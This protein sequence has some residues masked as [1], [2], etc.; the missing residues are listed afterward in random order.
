[1]KT[2]LAALFVMIY[3]QILSQANFEITAIDSFLS[4]GGGQGVSGLNSVT[5]NNQ[6]HLTY[7]YTDQNS[8]TH[9][10]YSVRDG[11]TLST[12]TV[13]LITEY[14]SFGNSTTLQF[15]GNG[16]KW[17]HAGFYSYPDR[18]IGSF[19]ETKS[20]WEY[21]FVD[22]TGDWKRVSSFV[23]G[24]GEIGFGYQGK[25]R[26]TNAQTIKYAKWVTDH[27]EIYNFTDITYPYRTNVSVVKSANKVFLSFGEG[28]YPDSLITRV[29][30]KED[31][32]WSES[33]V[34]LME[35]PYAGGGIDGLHAMIGSSPG[36]NP[37]L[38]HNLTNTS[39]P[40]FFKYSNKGW[41]QQTIN[42]LPGYLLIGQLTGSNLCVDS[43]NTAFVI[44]SGPRISWIK[45]NGDAG[46]TFIPHNYG[47]II[48][49]FT[50]LNDFVYI[51]YFDGYKEWPYNQPVTFK[52]AKINI[53]DLITDIEDENNTQP[54]K[55]ELFQNYPNPFNPTT[56]IAYSLPE[57]NFVNLS[58]YDILGRKVAQLINQERPAGNYSVEFS[59]EEFNTGIYV[60]RLMIQGKSISKKMLLI[61]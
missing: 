42:Y 49:D 43:Y 60:Y 59:A 47:C 33:L 40:R 26:Y 5:Y 50:I 24:S 8:V 52:E 17:I 10:M 35:I 56:T 21:F 57:R 54:E 51:Y 16:N 55:F 25:G 11:K 13:A 61:K 7:Y 58:V 28:R 46:Y 29:F 2:I 4:T 19:R 31:E 30:V 34:D 6:I 44:S 22:E 23:D 41:E 39:L 53:N 27:W 18:I 12:D 15:D 3:S 32:N 14:N 45:E 9:L 1:M 48:N 36:G 38:L 20:G 37:Y